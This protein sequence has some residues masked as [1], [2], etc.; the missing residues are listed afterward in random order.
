MICINDLRPIISQ[1]TTIRVWDNSQAKELI[2]PKTLYEGNINNLSANHKICSNPIVEMMSI[3]GVLV[4]FI[5]TTQNKPLK[6]YR[7]NKCVHE[8]RCS[9]DKDNE[10][11]C[12]DYKR[13][14]PDG[15]YY[16]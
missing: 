15:G 5:E 3:S 7:C 2:N 1:I 16:G 10:I 13:D 11:S 4:F 8:L 14:A 6:L 12:P 9:K